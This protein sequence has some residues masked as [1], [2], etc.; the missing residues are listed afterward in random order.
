MNQYERIYSLL[1]EDARTHSPRK[2][3]FHP[4][5]VPHETRRLL[6]L[7]SEL[8]KHSAEEH[9]SPE[10]LARV[11]R[12]HEYW[13]NKHA[14]HI[15]GH[16][17]PGGVIGQFTH[18]RTKHPKMFD[19]DGK[20]TP[21]DK[22]DNKKG[23]EEGIAQSIRDFRINRNTNKAVALGRQVKDLHKAKEDKRGPRIRNRWIENATRKHGKTGRKLYDLHRKSGKSHGWTRLHMLKTTGY[24][25]DDS[26]NTDEETP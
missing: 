14:E 26:W 25:P 4:Q 9:L 15:R 5:D 11:Q 23:L 16:P 24:A 20:I 10:Q 2:V 12:E 8:D 19:K 1:T 3:E 22:D 18:F 21:Q 13:T 17:N 6:H 7:K